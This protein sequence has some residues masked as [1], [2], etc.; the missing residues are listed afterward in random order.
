MV[1]SNSPDQ[2][3]FLAPIKMFVKISDG[4]LRRERRGKAVQSNSCAYVKR[5]IKSEEEAIKP[6]MAIPFSPCCFLISQYKCYSAAER[7]AVNQI[8]LNRAE[9][10]Q[11]SL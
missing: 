10:S 9:I 5:L 4:N 3:W 2:E 11:E 6:T 1:T 7:L 8:V